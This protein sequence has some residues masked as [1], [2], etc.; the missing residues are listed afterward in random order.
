MRGSAQGIR[1]PA[2]P[3]PLWSTSEVR[4]SEAPH[5]RGPGFPAIEQASARAKRPRSKDSSYS[6]SE[7][8]STTTNIGSTFSW[9]LNDIWLVSQLLGTPQLLWP[10]RSRPFSAEIGT[11]PLD[12]PTCSA[13][14]R[15]GSVRVPALFASR[16]RLFGGASSQKRSSKY[17]AFLTRVGFPPSLGTEGGTELG[18]PC[19]TRRTGR[20]EGGT[21]GGTGDGASGEPSGDSRRAVGMAEEEWPLFSDVFC[22]EGCSCFGAIRYVIYVILFWSNVEMV[23][24]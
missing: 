21:E 23:S 6:T 20:R 8:K 18:N 13:R 12:R 19:R 10:F 5:G 15:C 24:A 9:T 17:M 2:S 16:L 22:N 4:K 1:S 7:S 11:H 3:T 14:R